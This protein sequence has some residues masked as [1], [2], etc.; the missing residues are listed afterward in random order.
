MVVISVS[1]CPLQL[2][3]DLTKWMQEIDI[4]V[5]VGKMS[6]RVREKIWDRIC[7]NIKT[8]KAIMVYSAN[9]EQGYIILT[10]NTEWQSK[11]YDGLAVM[12]KP[13]KNGASESTLKKG[14]S[15]AARYE[16]AKYQ[17][18]FNEKSVEKKTEYV[19]VDVETTGFDYDNDSIIEIGLLKV[20]N[21]EIKQQYQSYIK[22]N[23]KIPEKIVNLTGITQ[24]I[25][26][27]SGK[28]EKQVLNDMK[29]II[30]NCI[31][32][33]YNIQFD[34]SFIHKSCEKHGIQPFIK[35]TKDILKLAKR[36]LDLG[37][38]KLETVCK[39]YGIDNS[40]LHRALNDCRV[41]YDILKEL[42][43]IM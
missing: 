8:G 15:K 29:S 32:I 26:D 43:E 6:A 42:N 36:K 39:Y 13:E 9:N 30:G 18:K 2:R 4:G 22:T 24:D 41:V 12:F 1:N 34:V 31:V 17:R 35:R 20:E 28:D 14:F 37:N 25:I 16:M 5:Y 19:I 10:H 33:G 11:D 27:K 7:G 23:S 21:D 3:G 38:Y 40:E